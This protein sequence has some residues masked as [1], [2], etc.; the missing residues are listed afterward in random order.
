MHGVKEAAEEWAKE[1]MWQQGLITKK[2]VVIV[3]YKRLAMTAMLRNDYDADRDVEKSE[4]V[5]QVQQR[6]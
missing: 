4:E 6:G 1:K 3:A 2:K 5:G